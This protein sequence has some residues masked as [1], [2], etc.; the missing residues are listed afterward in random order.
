METG[1]CAL[2]ER[3]AIVQGYL[4]IDGNSLGHASAATTVLKAGDM[5]TQAIYGTLRAVRHSMSRFPSLKPIV[6][7]DGMSW[8]KRAFEGYKAN[9]DKPAVQKYEIVAAKQRES[10]KEQRPFIKKGLYLLGVPQLTAINLEAD[11]LAGVLVRRYVAQGKKLLLIS[12]DKDW[13]QLVQPNVGW[14]DPIRDTSI[15]SKNIEEK[16]GV[17]NG[18]QWVQIKALMGDVS[19]NV[20]GVGGIGE[21]GALELIQTYGTVE[22]FVNQMIDG[23]IKDVP[24]KFEALARIEDKME[25]FKRNMMLMDLNHPQIPKA[26]ETEL[27]HSDLNYS[28]FRVFCE[29][30]MFRSILRE[31][32]D[33]LEPF[34]AWSVNTDGE[35]A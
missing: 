32:D 17:K 14:L 26:E 2:S 10:Y 28:E 1:C 20:T 29:E 25:I 35:A 21:K 23:T 7:W 22:D 18:R 4:I 6:C 13:I 9:R 3:E 33:W 27:L 31:Y 24:K 19:D 11:D 34:K 16:L 12:A 8:R 15:T 30:Y 5:E